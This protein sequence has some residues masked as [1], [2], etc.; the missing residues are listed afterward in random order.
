MSRPGRVCHESRP[1]RRPR[2]STSIRAS[3]TCQVQGLLLDPLAVC[4]P[5]RAL[6][7]AATA[8]SS[9]VKSAV[10]RSSATARSAGSRTRPS[11]ASTNA[12]LPTSF[13]VRNRAEPRRWGPE[14]RPGKLRGGAFGVGIAP[15]R[16][17]PFPDPGLRRAGS[18]RRWWISRTRGSGATTSEPSRPCR[19]WLAGATAS[20]TSNVLSRGRVP[21]SKHDP[22]NPQEQHRGR[23][24]SSIRV[25]IRLD[26]QGPVRRGGR[27]RQP[28]HRVRRSHPPL[29]LRE[30]SGR[31]VAPERGSR[32][33]GFDY[34]AGQQ[35]FFQRRSKARTRSGAARGLCGREL[36]AD[37]DWFEAQAG[38]ASHLPGSQGL[39]A[40]SWISP[41][42]GI[43]VSPVEGQWLRAPISRAPSRSCR[44]PCR[45]IATVGL[46]PND[47]PA[48]GQ[49]DTPALRW[50]AEWSR[51]SS[52]PVEY[53][54]AIGSQPERAHPEHGRELRDRQGPDRLGRR[55]RNLW[56]GYGIGI[57]GTVGGAESEIRSERAW[58]SR[59]RSFRTGSRAPAS[60]SCTRA[61]LRSRSTETYVGERSATFAIFASTA[62]GHRRRD[63]LGDARPAPAARA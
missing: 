62:T 57:F 49:T 19:A 17:G 26:A 8:R 3:T 42:V 29:W 33:A 43:G 22:A 36:A 12:P 46:I 40:E 48:G 7:S 10:A 9:M 38:S 24:H 35:E 52:P 14:L 61:G 54:R 23:Q 37:Y 27:C 47:L 28:L 55:D 5:D 51:A 25:L 2:A 13:D 18:S 11:T 34:L 60:P 44:K 21:G 50:D 1:S 6:R 30:Q 58:A 16:R 59:C 53:Q 63:H 39:P 31:T 20:A 4:R 32:Y 15:E 45:P 41:R 56:L